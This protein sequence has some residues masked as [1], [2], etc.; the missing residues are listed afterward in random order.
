MVR[1]SAFAGWLLAAVIAVAAASTAAQQDEG[2]ILKPKARPKPSSATILVVCDLYCNWTLDGEDRGSI[3]AGHSARAKV[4]FGEHLVVTATQDGTDRSQQQV[5]INNS[6]QRL[7]LAKLTEVRT[8]RIQAQQA[9]QAEQTKRAQAEQ[10]QRVQAEEEQ[11]ARAERQ[12][13][14]ANSVPPNLTAKELYWRAID[15]AR[16]DQ[17]A[18]AVEFFKAACD[19]GDGKSCTTAGTIYEQGNGVPKNKTRAKALYQKACYD[20]NDMGCISLKYLR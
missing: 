12:A 19:K 13:E 6:G 9:G 17:N 1:I 10:T 15:L 4:D 3:A 16:E 18:F 5:T 7:V 14:Q 11:K 20:G 2:P 8:A